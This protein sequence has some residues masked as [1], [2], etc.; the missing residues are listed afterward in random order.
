MSK[1]QTSH[2]VD[3]FTHY[4]DFNPRNNCMTYL[5]NYLLI[6]SL[7]TISLIARLVFANVQDI[8]LPVLPLPKLLLQSL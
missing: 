3:Q 2:Y 8:G 5:L 1:N 7:L 4:A 6:F